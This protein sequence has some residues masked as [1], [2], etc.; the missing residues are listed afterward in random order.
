MNCMCKK[1]WSVGYYGLKPTFA[2]AFSGDLCVFPPRD[3]RYWA[4]RET[5][6]LESL[7]TSR[8]APAENGTCWPMMAAAILNTLTR[9]CDE[10]R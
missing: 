9:V 4:K 8:I 6:L 10:G 1:V 3:V 5:E 2:P 7:V